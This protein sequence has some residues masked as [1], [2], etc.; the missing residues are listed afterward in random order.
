MNDESQIPSLD[1]NYWQA[2]YDDQ[3]TGWDRGSFHPSLMVWKHTGLKAD[4]SII[5]PGCGRGHEVLEFAKQGLHVTA[6]DYAPSALAFLEGQLSEQKL[7]AKVVNGDLFEYAPPTPVDAVY[8]Q[9]CLCAIAPSDRYAQLLKSWL[10][11]DGQLYVLFAQTARKIGPPFHCDVQEMHDLFPN[12]DWKW[13]EKPLNAYP[14]PSGE[15]SE[16]GTV[17]F[18]K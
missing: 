7:S 18:R 4:H 17:L 11:P 15:I 3:S 8:E 2:R 16:L 12:Q 1:Q 13:S 9:T 6:I 10:K 5:V 14:H